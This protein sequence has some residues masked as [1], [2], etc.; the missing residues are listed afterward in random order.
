M[1][2]KIDENRSTPSH[3]TV[4]FQNSEDKMKI[5]QRKINKYIK[6]QT[7]LIR[8]QNGFRFLKY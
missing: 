2:D 5:S 6:H 4:K 7:F 8:N 1:P 3:T